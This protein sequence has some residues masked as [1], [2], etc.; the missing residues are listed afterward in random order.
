MAGALRLG[1]RTFAMRA[2]SAEELEF[3]RLVLGIEALATVL[4]SALFMLSIQR[5]QTDLV[6]ATFLATA[7]AAGVVNLAVAW[8][9]V[10]R[11]ASYLEPPR[12]SAR[13]GQGGGRGGPRKRRGPESHHRAPKPPRPAFKRGADRLNSSEPLQRA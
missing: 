1:R 2:R 4:G 6:P 7:A 10:L 3:R 9:A 5:W 12:K 13:D 8:R 11:L